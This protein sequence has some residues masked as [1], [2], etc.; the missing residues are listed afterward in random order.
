MTANKILLALLAPIVLMT[1]VTI[2]M[3]G[4]EHWFSALGPTDKARTMLGRV[5][6]AAPYALAAGT[7]IILLFATAGSSATKVI[8][9]GSFAGGMATLLIALIRET[10]RLY[11]LSSEVPP[12]QSTLAYTDPSTVVG[13]LLTFAVTCF[14]LRVALIGNNAFSARE[15]RRVHGQ[16]AIH[17]D[18]AWMTLA[19]AVELFPDTGGIVVG[20]NYRV[21]KDDV[22]GQHFRADRRHTWGRGGKSP[23]L[24]FDGSFGSSHGIV[25]AG[26]GGFKTTSVTIPSALKWGGSIV[27]LDPSRKVGDLVSNHRVKAGRHVHF[28]DPK[29]PE[30]GVNVLDWIGRFGGT[31]EE[32]IAS[33]ASWIVS[34]SAKFNV[35]DDF[36]RGSGLQLLTALIADV[37][38]SGHTENRTRP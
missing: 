7:A 3:S 36:F 21:D 17:G 20:E 33:V 15:P 11:A 18:A 24:C 1:A 13:A 28:L 22:A 16:R 31:K 26:S 12:G 29:H 9:W 35:R 6:I 14:S 19:D 25:F 8:G 30:S 27:L 5:G 2:G 4:L 38:L 10:A 23:L 32:D 37:C 34:D